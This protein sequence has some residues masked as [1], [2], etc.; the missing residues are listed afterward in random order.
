[1]IFLSSP[2][3]KAFFQDISRSGDFF[4]DGT[5]LDSIFMEILSR[6]PPSNF[7]QPPYSLGPLLDT[8][9]TLVCCDRSL[10]VYEISVL[11]DL[12]FRTV[13][14]TILGPS[15]ALFSTNADGHIQLSTPLL[16][17]FLLD[18]DRSGN[19]FIG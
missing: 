3:L 5:G 10:S 13:E 12:D 14:R 19:F 4:I 7:T 9:T 6:Q 15:R 11:A 18:A 1:M 8:L 2:S 16:K 17:P